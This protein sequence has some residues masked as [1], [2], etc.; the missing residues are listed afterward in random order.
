MPE[1]DTVNLL[2]LKTAIQEKIEAFAARTASMKEE[3]VAFGLKAL[4]VT[5]TY[6]EKKGSSEPLEE[7]IKTIAGVGNV[8]VIDVRRAFG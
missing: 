1:D 8:D 2:S 4:I 5:L 3:P 7:D 6:N